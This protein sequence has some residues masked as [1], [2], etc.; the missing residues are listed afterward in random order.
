MFSTVGAYF[1]EYVYSMKTD[2]L[3][4]CVAD[5]KREYKGYLNDPYELSLF[6]NKQLYLCIYISL[7]LS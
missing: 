5:V 1:F 4:L 7:I 2:N 6:C 3:H